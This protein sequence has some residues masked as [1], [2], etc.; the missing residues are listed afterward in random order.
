MHDKTLCLVYI[1]MYTNSYTDR[2]S[3]VGRVHVAKNSRAIFPRAYLDTRTRSPCRRA[4]CSAGRIV[5]RVSKFKKA[6][7]KYNKEIPE[8]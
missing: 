2:A 7:R 8:K 6:T 5:L 4:F 3:V 1:H